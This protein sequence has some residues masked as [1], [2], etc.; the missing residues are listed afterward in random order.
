[1]TYNRGQLQIG[2]AIINA[3]G[4]LGSSLLGA[5]GISSRQTAVLERTEEL[6]YKELKEIIEANDRRQM[7]RW[8][9]VKNILDRIAPPTVKKQAELF[10]TPAKRISENAPLIGGIDERGNPI[11]E[12]D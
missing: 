10:T 6:H 4:L 12:T 8:D 9:E 2:V 5:W 11:N 7:Q 3:I 1:M